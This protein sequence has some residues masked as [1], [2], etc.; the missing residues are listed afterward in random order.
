MH[1]KAYFLIL[2]I[3]LE[4]LKFILIHMVTIV[5]MS[6]ELVTL[7]LLKIKIFSNK[8]YDVIMFVHD[9]TNIILS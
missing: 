4:S 2:L 1:F 3:F 8:F 7:D 9:V 6:A 5:M